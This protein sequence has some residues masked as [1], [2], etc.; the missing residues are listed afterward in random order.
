MTPQWVCLARR[1]C[2]S[3]RLDGCDGKRTHYARETVRLDGCDGRRR[4]WA[5]RAALLKR[6]DVDTAL[7]AIAVL[8]SVG[9]LSAFGLSARSS[10]ADG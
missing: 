4:H 2:A 8:A 7:A 6:P 3:A 1:P 5:V 9:L 10:S